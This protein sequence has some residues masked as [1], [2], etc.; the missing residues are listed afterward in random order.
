[1]KTEETC[2]VAAHQCMKKC[3]NCAHGACSK[4]EHV[5]D[6]HYCNYCQKEF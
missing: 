4:D 3:P 2:D 6:I 5:E 1:M